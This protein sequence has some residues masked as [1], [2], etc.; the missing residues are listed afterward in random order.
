MATVNSID[1][2]YDN[3]VLICVYH[4][5]P[6]SKNNDGFFCVKCQKNNNKRFKDFIKKI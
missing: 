5:T 1:M 2:K 4:K 6:I 3:G